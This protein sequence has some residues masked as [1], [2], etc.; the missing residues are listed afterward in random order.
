MKDEGV[1]DERVMKDEGVMDEGVMKNGVV[2]VCKCVPGSPPVANSVSADSR[3]ALMLY[4][5]AL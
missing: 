5:A 4:D 3:S 1:M 2:E